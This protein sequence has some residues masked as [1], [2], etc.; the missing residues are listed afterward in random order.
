MNL[1][2]RLDMNWADYREFLLPR[3]SPITPLRRRRRRSRR[4]RRPPPFTNRK[5]ESPDMQ[6]CFSWKG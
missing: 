4:S 3:L 2:T 5:I 1:E 6:G